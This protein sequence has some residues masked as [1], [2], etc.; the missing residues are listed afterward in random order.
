MKIHIKRK[1]SNIVQPAWRQINVFGRLC[2]LLLFCTGTN[3]E[4]VT[5]Q[6]QGLALN[7]ELSLAANKTLAEGVIL[8]THGGLAHR[9]MESLRYLRTLLSER[10]YN[11]LAIN[12]SL[13]IN[14]RHGMYDCQVTHRHRNE[15]AVTE[16]AL[17]M[18]WLKQQGVTRVTL[19]GHSRGGAQTALYAAERDNALI[20]TMVLMAPA[21][22]DNGA[23]G[24]EKR[25]LQ[26][27]SPTLTRAQTLIKN[28]RQD[29]PLAHVNI[30]LCTDTKATAASFVSY[31]APS[32]R[33]DT[34]ALIPQIRQP[35]LV[36]V[37]GNDNV[38]RGLAKKITP[39]VDGKQVQMVTVDDAD[40]TF[41]DLYAD[42]AVDAIDQFLRD[43]A[44]P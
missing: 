23:D 15:D 10:G 6:H 38:V 37:A 32:P 43:A 17:W 29:E 27:L 41:R 35:V 24:Y 18:D 21:T 34:P 26:A 40:H 5:L 1:W 22:K 30:M 16:I 2:T 44:H 19:L 28:G 25:Y 13:G 11:T 9:D 31:Y 36:I 12:L 42:D 33:L 8:I 39:L 14:N 4:Q 20:D 3:A 7:A